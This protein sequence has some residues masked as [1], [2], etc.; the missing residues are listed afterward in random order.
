MLKT[1]LLCR[2]QSFNNGS[3]AAWSY[4]NSPLVRKGDRVFCTDSQIVPG[5]EPFNH[6]S[7]RL[8]EKQDGGEWKI[9]FEDE[10]V[11]QREP[12]PVLLAGNRLLVTVNP[13]ARPYEPSEPSRVVPC[14]PLLYVFDVSGTVKLEKV[15]PMPWDTEQYHFLDHSYRGGAVDAITGDLFFD[16]L[17][18]PPNSEGE[19]VYGLLDGNLK[20]IKTAP[21]NFPDRSC[22]HNIAIRGG[23]AY[24]F[25]VRDIVEPNETW[26]EYKRQVTGQAWDYDFRII[27]MN[28]TP[29]IR[30]RD[31]LPTVQ[32]CDRDQTCG[33]TKN[34]DCCYTA[35]GD[36]LLAVGTRN[37]ATAF[38]RDRFFPQEALY[39][40]L[41]VYRFTHGVCQESFIVDSA[42]E[43][44]GATVNYAAFFH[45]AA[46]GDVYLVW[47]KTGYTETDGFENGTYL[48]SMSE[49]QSRL[50]TNQ[51]GYLFGSKTRL[52]AAPDDRLDILWITDEEV[53]YGN[54]TL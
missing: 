3:M 13:T 34:L 28:Y 36:M 23:E 42:S 54:L 18:Y 29:D 35:A 30:R 6:T 22:Y 14:T 11:F 46:N 43:E 52:G 37:V 48:M 50:L 20:T 17:H 15:L 49:R 25:A 1:Q 5:R 4:G 16:N 40:R 47:D 7:M 38:M 31:F 21:L 45:T 12:C 51:T 9:V 53:R 27:R 24:V 33:W 41:E 44:D 19:H 32:V 39:S 8:F 10:G 2:T 26:R